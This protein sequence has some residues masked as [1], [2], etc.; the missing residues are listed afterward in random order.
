MNDLFE[1][2]RELL[3]ALLRDNRTDLL[4][5]FYW[6]TLRERYSLWRKYCQGVQ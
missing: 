2:E 1:W 6:L 3:T 4:H 5:D